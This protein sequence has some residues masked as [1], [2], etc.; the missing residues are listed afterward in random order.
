M[1]GL[2]T[3]IGGTFRRAGSVYVK[4]SG[5]WR[6]AKTIWVK[7]AG[8]WRQMG[9]GLSTSIIVGT[10][11]SYLTRKGYS[12]SPPCGS[13]ATAG[14][15]NG[16]LLTG[17]YAE[18]DFPF[19]LW[20]SQSGPVGSFIVNL[21]DTANGTPF[22]TGTFSNVGS[23]PVPLVREG[24]YNLLNARTGSTVFIDITPV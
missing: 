6:K 12:L 17:L 19:Y 13:I 7:V 3:K 10:Y 22:L 8:V 24:V 5:S 23:T 14:L 9:F 2:F 20:M 21:R 11:T 16:G 18:S 4:V 15:P 1:A